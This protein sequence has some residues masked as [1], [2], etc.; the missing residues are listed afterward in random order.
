[1]EKH[2][3]VSSYFTT[4]EYIEPSNY[5]FYEGKW[6]EQLE[7]RE[8]SNIIHK[9]LIYSIN[10]EPDSTFCHTN[11]QDGTCWSAKIL[12]SAEDEYI[13]FYHFNNFQN[14]LELFKEK[15]YKFIE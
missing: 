9:A 12:D 10:Y 4:N 13:L 15:G 3:Y 6:F 8:N 2:I 7:T 14:L 5:K 1:M 11:G